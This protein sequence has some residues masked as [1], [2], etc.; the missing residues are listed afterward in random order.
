MFGSGAGS[1]PDAWSIKRADFLAY[2]KKYP[3]PVEGKWAIIDLRDQHNGQGSSAFYCHGIDN[4]VHSQLPS[5][6]TPGSS[7]QLKGAMHAPLSEDTFRA[8]SKMSFSGELRNL[9][10]IGKRAQTPQ[11]L[12]E[13]KA[14]VPSKFSLSVQRLTAMTQGLAEGAHGVPV[15]RAG[16]QEHSILPLPPE[17]QPYAIYGLWL[18]RVWSTRGFTPESHHHRRRI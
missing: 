5:D 9:W 10:A 8:S 14:Y 16:G 6:F 1:N 3:D 4:P 7:T 11:E 12:S 15:L 18:S 13:R 17:H 2:M